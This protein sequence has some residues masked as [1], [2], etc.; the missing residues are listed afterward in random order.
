MNHP[1]RGYLAWGAQIG[2]VTLR[3]RG[4][5]LICPAPKTGSAPSNE[6]IA[7]ASSGQGRTD[8]LDALYNVRPLLPYAYDTDTAR[9]LCDW[10]P[11][12][13]RRAETA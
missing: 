9:M 1:S 3:V 5:A 12:P 2:V 7:A 4:G 13:A 11:V 8:C 10:A 6:P